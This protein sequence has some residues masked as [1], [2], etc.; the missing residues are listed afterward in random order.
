[1]ATTTEHLSFILETQLQS[2]DDTDCYSIVKYA[3]AWVYAIQAAIESHTIV[4]WGGRGKGGRGLSRR[5]FQPHS[6][7]LENVR[8]EYV[9]ESGLPGKLLLDAA[10]L[11]ILSQ[12]VYAL[13]GR[14]GCGKS[15]LL[16]RIDAGKIPGFPPHLTSMYI[17]QE[18]VMEPSK[19][20]LDF[21]LQHHDT[22]LQRSRD[23]NKSRIESLETELEQ[24]EMASE[25][26][27]Q[28]M[29]ELCEQISLLEDTT[30]GY[31]LEV[32]RQQAQEALVFFGI[33]ESS[34]N[35]PMERLSGGERKKVVLACALFC[36]TDLLLLDEPTNFLDIEGLV[37]LRRLISTCID[38]NS[39]VILISHDVDL[40][41]DLATDVIHFHDQSLTYYPGNYHDFVR[42]KR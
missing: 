24:L 34:W 17:P 10:F 19:I 12:R 2:L 13:V 37:Q 29:E 16:R 26:D 36:R 35:V 5:T 11:K 25:D 30:D 40:I 39:T 21:L 28:R 41:N 27:T 9:N 1:M 42:Y 32:V 14:N 15:T 8:L 6:V 23:A 18:V 3:S 31:D 22:F 4:S 33:E 38:R 20:P 7:S